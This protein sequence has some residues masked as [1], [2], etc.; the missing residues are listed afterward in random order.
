MAAGKCK[1][2]YHT[3]EYHGFEC[4]ITEGPCM[5]LYPDSEACASQYGEGPDAVEFEEVSLDEIGESLNELEQYKKLGTLE[6][7]REAVEKQ[8]AKKP[9]FDK[10]LMILGCPS[11][12]Y[13]LQK[14]IDD[15]STEGFIP[16]Y[17]SNCGQ[18]IDSCWN[19]KES[20]NSHWKENF[21]N[22]FERRT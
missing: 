20:E 3:N 9:E 6:E 7:V 18:K 13:Y 14:V 21:L 15:D 8:K 5:F 16:N 22:R 1:A 17:C 12:G 11:C 19:I 10:P 2:A 4:S